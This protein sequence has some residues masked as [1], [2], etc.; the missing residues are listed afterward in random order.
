M[1][2]WIIRNRRVLEALR[3]F[4]GDGY[5]LDEALSSDSELVFVKDLPTQ[6]IFD[7]SCFSFSM[8]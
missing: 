2:G 8:I 4:D 5:H 1:A 6:V 7:I 3:D